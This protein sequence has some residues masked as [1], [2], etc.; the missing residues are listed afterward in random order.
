MDNKQDK[1][2]HCKDINKWIYFSTKYHEL[3]EGSILERKKINLKN[4]N[5]NNR[6]K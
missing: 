2:R 4:T 5:R 3:H 6:N 1:E